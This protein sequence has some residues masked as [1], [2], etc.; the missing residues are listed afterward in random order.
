[1]QLQQFATVHHALNTQTKMS[2]AV[3]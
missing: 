1:M 2:L 3:V